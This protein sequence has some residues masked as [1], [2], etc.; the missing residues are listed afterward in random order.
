MKKGSNFLIICLSISFFLVSCGNAD[1]KRESVIDV[2]E[3]SF[4]EE[5]ILSDFD[6]D[7][8]Q[9]NFTTYDEAKEVI[10][11][12]VFRIEE[13]VNTSKSSWVRGASYYSCD[14]ITGFFLIL[15]DSQDYLHSDVPVNVWKGFKNAESFG[16]YYN[17]FIKNQYPFTLN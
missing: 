8:M 1:P 3:E 10:E 14:G 5:S 2:P 11:G 6:C 15:T 12:T 9:S 13:T 4:E 16:S 7:D 17:K